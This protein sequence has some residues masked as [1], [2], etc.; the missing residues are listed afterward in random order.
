MYYVELLDNET[1]DV[2]RLAE[3]EERELAVGA[4]RKVIDEF[5]QQNY[6]AGIAGSDLYKLFAAKGK[7]PVIFQAGSETVNVVFNP[8]TYAKARVAELCGVE[9]AADEGSQA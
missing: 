5:L 7:T 2:E 1:G 6:R 8:L 3:F 9:G 4:A